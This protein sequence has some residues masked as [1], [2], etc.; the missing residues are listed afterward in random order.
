MNNKDNHNNM[1]WRTAFLAFSIMVLILTTA[2]GDN[3]TA[4]PRTIDSDT[5]QT[6]AVNDEDVNQDGLVEQYRTTVSHAKETGEIISFLNENLAK[7][8]EKN[9]DIMIRE[10][11]VF[12]DADLERTQDA[13]FQPKVQESLMALPWPITS[14]NAGSIEDDEIK[15]LVVTKLSGGYK[16]VEV[17]GSIYP[18]VD[19]EMQKKM[20]SNYLSEPL[21]QYITLKALE[22]NEMSAKDGGLVI[23][24]D[25]LA[26]RAVM[27][28]NFV[29]R[30]PDSPEWE[31][32]KQTY[33]QRYLSIYLIGL[34]NTPVFDYETYK[35]S[36]EVRSSYERLISLHPDTVTAKMAQR[37]LDVLAETKGQVFT[38]INGQQSDIAVVRQFHDSF[39][40]EAESMLIPS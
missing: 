5:S 38:K 29:K 28:E 36:S 34:N 15:Q 3:T 1:G 7:A 37:F 6:S 40:S 4:E 19:Y 21:N 12:Y 30:Y 25:E 31:E 10:L 39:L 2:C 33:L 23:S 13:F 11:N 24:W 26:N 8:G 9:A 27:S 14:A 20:S 17:E 22:S 18:I 35:L 16:L 32:V